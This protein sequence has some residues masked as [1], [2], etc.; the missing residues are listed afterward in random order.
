MIR[1]EDRASQVIHT[2]AR[3]DVKHVDLPR[4]LSAE[5]DAGPP[6]VVVPPPCLLPQVGFSSTPPFIMALLRRKLLAL[7]IPSAETF[8]VSGEHPSHLDCHPWPTRA[9]TAVFEAC[10]HTCCCLLRCPA[11][12]GMVRNLFVSREWRVRSD[13]WRNG[14]IAFSADPCPPVRCT[15]PSL[16]P[17]HSG[18]HENPPLEN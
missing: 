5:N 15:N 6:I 12:D 16:T 2:L 7:D 17:S 4:E 8:D 10:P 14:R 3:C 9:L 1:S 13:S 11:D 18:G